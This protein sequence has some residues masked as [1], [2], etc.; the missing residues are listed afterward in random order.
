MCTCPELAVE[1]LYAC[2]QFTFRCFHFLGPVAVKLREPVLFG[3]EMKHGRSIV[4]DCD[5]FLLIML[6]LGPLLKH[7]RGCERPEEESYLE[8][9][10]RVLH[11][12]LSK[13]YILTDSLRLMADVGQLERRIPV[14]MK[15]SY[16][17]FKQIVGAECGIGKMRIIPLLA[18]AFGASEPGPEIR[19]VQSA[20]AAAHLENKACVSG[21]NCNDPVG[22]RLYPLA[23]LGRPDR[24][25]GVC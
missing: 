11:H 9:V 6:Y 20:V 21:L 3:I 24:V 22:F 10:L 8:G 25:L 18:E 7:I 15:G 17:R 5:R 12:N 19:L 23:C 14:V 1:D 16:S 2:C 13:S 4:V